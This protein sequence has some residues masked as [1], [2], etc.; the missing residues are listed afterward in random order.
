[1]LLAD[2][3]ITSTA[4]ADI[5]RYVDSNGDV[6]YTNTP[7]DSRFKIHRRFDDSNPIASTFAREIRHYGPRVRE[8]YEQEIQ[9]A[10][11]EHNIDPALIHAVI[12][13]ESGYNPFARSQRGAAGLMQ[14]MP[15]TARRFGARNR[16]DP[17][18]NIHAGVR[19]LR[20]LMELFDHDLEL[21]LAAYNA[22]ETA[23]IRAGRRIPQY[24]ETMTYVPRVL[25]YYRRY[26]TRL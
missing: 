19:Y 7:N 16:L 17:G 18:E 25:E 12:S 5:F 15:E 8:R 26:R 9:A 6:H 24:S 20:T 21:V 4:W 23:V 10:A 14:L 22:G 2:V 1:M 11:K 13:V 3:S